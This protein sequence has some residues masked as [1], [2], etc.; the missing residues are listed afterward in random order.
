MKDFSRYDKN[1]NVIYSESVGLEG[2]TVRHFYKYDKENRRIY[3]RKEV[4]DTT[5]EENTKY[6][7]T[8]MIIESV[9]LPTYLTT[10]KEYNKSGRLLSEVTYDD[11]TGIIT[12]KHYDPYKDKY[13][14]Y[15]T[16]SPCVIYNGDKEESNFSI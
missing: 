13:M 12:H 2:A 3:Y 9:F 6:T 14:F 15:R 5:Y 11:M 4:L 16:M 7:N 1:G 8:G 10:Y